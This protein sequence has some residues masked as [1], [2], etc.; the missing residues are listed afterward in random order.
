MANLVYFGLDF[1]FGTLDVACTLSFSIHQER[2]KSLHL[3]KVMHDDEEDHL[4]CFLCK[5][6]NEQK[7]CHRCMIC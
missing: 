4:H 5:N 6:A 3:L 1:I 2:S 7:L